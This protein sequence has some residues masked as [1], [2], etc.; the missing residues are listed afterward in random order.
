MSGNSS[1]NKRSITVPIP[2]TR[3]QIDGLKPA[4]AYNVTVQAGTSYGYG[5][6]VWC[7]FATLDSDEANILKLRSRTPN[8]LTVYWPANWL[9]KTTS[10]FTVPILKTRSLY[11]FQCSDQ[12]K[13][14]SFSNRSIQGN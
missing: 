5:N 14:H 3:L 1:T 6:K 12:S 13:D 2:L 7:A 10:K 8:S 4:T 11:Y 9:T